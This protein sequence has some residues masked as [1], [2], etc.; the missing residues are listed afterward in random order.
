MYLQQSNLNTKNVIEWRR[1][2]HFETV[3]FKEFFFNYQ[4][5]IR[6]SKVRK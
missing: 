4:L 5:H 3:M 6:N 1:P 2:C